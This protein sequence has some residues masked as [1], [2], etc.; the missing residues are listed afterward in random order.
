MG[1]GVGLTVKVEVTVEVAVGLAGGPGVL[2]ELGTG[3]KA[4]RDRLQEDNAKMAQR[5]I[6]KI[7]RIG[8]E[9]I[10]IMLTDRKSLDLPR[11]KLIARS[12]L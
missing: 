10:F 6:P 11:Q 2:V 3:S 4:G 12:H 7:A 1:S 8:F 5:W 9:N